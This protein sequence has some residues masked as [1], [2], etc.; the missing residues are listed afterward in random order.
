MVQLKRE[1]I[2]NVCDLE[3]LS[4]KEQAL[5]TMAKVKNSF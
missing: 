4:I 1:V 2:M 3:A 5:L